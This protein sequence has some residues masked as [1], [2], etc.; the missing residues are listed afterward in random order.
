MSWNSKVVWSEG[1]LLQPQHLQ[2]HDRYLETQLETRVGNLRP[3]AWGFTELKID[4]QHLA[5]GK[6]TL[7]SCTGVFPDGTPFSL[8]ADDDLPL[9]L[10]IPAEA[11]N[12]LAMLALPLRRP[13]VPE[14]TAADAADSYA[15][16]CTVDYAAWDSNGLDN[17]A[18]LQV[19]RLR[20][21][22]AL[23]SEV[24]QAY[25]GLGVVRIIERRADNQV[26]IDPDYCPPCLRYRVAPRIGAYADEL[27]A[28]LRQRGGALADRLSQ[29]GVTGAAE[30]ADFLLLQLI[31]RMQPMFAHFANTSVLHP[32][33]L[34]REMLQLAG[35]LATFTRDDKRAARYPEYRHDHLA[36]SFFPVMADLRWSL[37]M[38]PDPAAVAI[39]LEERQYGFHVAVISDRSLLKSATFILAVTAQVP[40]ETVR[41]DFPTQFKVAS[42]ERIR[43]LVAS[44][45]PGIKLRPLPV[46][47]RQL[48]FHA[49]YT[50]FELD[51]ECDEWKHLQ[52]SAGFGMHVAGDFPELQMQ[53]WAIR[54]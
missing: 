14:T 27:L 23:E 34:Y 5:L 45:L 16:H 30:I 44:A 21:R 29:P 39:L 52:R 31:N 35:E 25:T 4:E 12:V 24:V 54:R 19:G 2:Q 3:Y 10:D 28:L 11:R 53:F 9:P 7:K 18:Q 41:N 46:A 49:G 20:V 48:P 26:A 42:V 8:P 1:M 47:P 38:L 51:A 33:A 36:E 40:S 50:Y 22:L 17:T 37:A 13:G 6:L 43:D 15:R 32:E